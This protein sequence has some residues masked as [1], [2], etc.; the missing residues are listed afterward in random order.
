[1]RRHDSSSCAVFV[2]RV[3]LTFRC[4]H[5]TLAS[6]SFGARCF[7]RDVNS[8][9]ILICLPLGSFVSSFFETLS[10]YGTEK[11]QMKP[12]HTDF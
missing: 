2:H 5:F 8:F 1:V 10:T 7:L 4:L 9:K 12:E 3:K 6:I 11:A